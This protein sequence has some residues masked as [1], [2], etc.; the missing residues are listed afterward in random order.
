MGVTDPDTAFAA[1]AQS[2]L[3]KPGVTAGTGF[4]AN[5]GLRTG[6][7]IF[8]MLAHGELV[9]KLP[10]A[11][12]TQLVDAATARRFDAGKGRPMKEWITV[13]EAAHGD[14]PDLAR[15]ALAFVGGR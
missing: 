4:G 8:A 11:R 2:L 1:I 12:C 3:G 9:V 6:G 14:W 5:A 13:G 15:E 7:R 10:A